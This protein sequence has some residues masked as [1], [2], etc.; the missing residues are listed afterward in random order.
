MNEGDLA[1]AKWQSR[2]RSNDQRASL[3]SWW[4]PR[5]TLT[6]VVSW[7]FQGEA[8]MGYPRAIALLQTP[9]GY[10]HVVLQPKRAERDQAGALTEK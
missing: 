3:P 5:S 8:P 9:V 10:S 7:T 1:A 6:Y 2:V 4:G